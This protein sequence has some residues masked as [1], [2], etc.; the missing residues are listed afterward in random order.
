MIF[1]PYSKPVTLQNS[2]LA[3]VQL[4]VLVPEITVDSLFTVVADQP[5]TMPKNKRPL[6]PPFFSRIPVS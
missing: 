6:L 2:P 3:S 1:T 5:I 4:P